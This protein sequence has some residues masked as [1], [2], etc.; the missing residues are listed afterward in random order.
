MVDLREFKRKQCEA[1]EDLIYLHFW[2]HYA[3]LVMGIIQPASICHV[4]PY[5]IQLPSNAHHS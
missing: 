3:L 2:S 5:S 4:Y 1:N